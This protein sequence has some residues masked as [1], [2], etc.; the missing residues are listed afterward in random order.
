MIK[1][2]PVSE[3]LDREFLELRA[4]LLQIAAQLDRLDRATG[5]VR[6][7]SR[8]EGIGRALEVLAGDE[9]GRAEKV[10]LIFSRQYEPGWKQK[11]ALH[12]GEHA[13][14]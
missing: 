14:S 1:Q 8:L 4:G 7:D 12:S 3:V 5:P 2:P 11:L 6:C 13:E 10:Q 9:V